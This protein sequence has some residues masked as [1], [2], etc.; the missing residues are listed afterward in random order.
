MYRN[1]RRIALSAQFVAGISMLAGIVGVALALVV[2]NP[3]TT[4]IPPLL[5]A[6]AGLGYAVRTASIETTIERLDPRLVLAAYCLVAAGAIALYGA[7]GYSRPIEVHA[8]VLVL[9]LVTVLGA[10][11]LES[12][13]LG[14]GLVVTTG[15]VHRGMVYY[16]SAIQIGM[17]ALY[18]NRVAEAIAAA[19]SMAPLATSKYWYAPV[20]HLLT[21]S[22]AEA[23]GV[24]ARHAAFVLVTVV[25]TVVVAG[26]VFLLLDRVWGP[27]VGLVGATVLLAADKVI[28]ATIHTT[29]TTIGV[30]LFA[31]LLCCTEWYIE[32]RSRAVGALLFV[33]LAGLVGTHQLSL[34]VAV[35]TLNAYLLGSLF[36]S[37]TLDRTVG[38]IQAL[39]LVAFLLQAS[40]TRYNGPA[41]DAPSFIL[42]TG[43]WITNELTGLLDGATSR[44]SARLPA[45]AAAALSGADA[46]SWVQ[47]L[48]T[49]LLFALAVTGAVYWLA[50]R[51][52]DD[53]RIAFSL[54]VGVVTTSVF[55]FVLP[56]VG[57]SAFLSGRWTT[58]LYVLL[59]VLSAPAIVALLSRARSAPHS[60]AAIALVCLL[61]GAPYLVVMTGNGAGAPD[62]P[63]L[64][65]S[66]SAGRLG[67]TA[68]EASL[69][70]FTVDSAADE[71]LVV[72][73]FSAWQ[74]LS[75]YYD[76][77]TARYATAYETPGTTFDGETLVVYRG[78]ADTNHAS[79]YVRYEGTRYRVYGDL[80]GPYARDS[81]VYTNGEDR[82]AWRVES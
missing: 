45:D 14:F 50:Q 12:P 31:L 42:V 67:T 8:L 47:V 65:E 74:V 7:N 22:G 3:Y 16:A 81:I 63:L 40:I 28:F 23:M 71:T 11:A 56:M 34:F 5:A 66:P 1:A 35:V 19:E 58:F 70:R 10:F 30:A 79:Y 37:G 15:V 9:Y 48:G 57:V 51:D 68:Q 41:G 82:L 39:L 32:T 72:A 18:H 75:R 27:T 77:P 29:P 55:V 17:D 54:G 20:Y 25:S 36:W 69:Y 6:G 78:Y 60:I 59:A 64:D 21:A 62:D 38:G 13:R 33:A 61:V 80:P 46:L 49:G 52:G 73:D 4:V 24:S 26:A 43:T 76:H 2:S 53:G 44:A